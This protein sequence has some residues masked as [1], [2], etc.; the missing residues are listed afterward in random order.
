MNG[1][2]IATGMVLVP[3]AIAYA[4]Q[5]R[6]QSDEGAAKWFG[7]ENMPRKLRHCV[8]FMNETALEISR[9]IGV[10]GRVDQVYKNPDGKLIIV[11]TKTRKK[12]QVFPDDVF[13]VSLYRLLVQYSQRKTVLDTAYIRTVVFLSNTRKT[14]KYHPITLMPEQKIL[15]RYQQL[16]KSR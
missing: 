9:P 1:Y 16:R 3:L 7:D 5:Y 8:L 12:H 11:D 6:R 4:D 15:Q 14:V 10:R 13:Q 2:V